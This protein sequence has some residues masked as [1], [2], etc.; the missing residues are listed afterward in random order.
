MSCHNY[1][2][3]SVL[4][5][6]SRENQP[7]H[8]QNLMNVPYSSVSF[9]CE[10]CAPPASWWWSGEGGAGLRRFLATALFSGGGV[11]DPENARLI[12]D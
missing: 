4:K 9:L 3:K 10:L 7:S 12:R 2:D 1:L 6:A 11:S 8:H 5:H